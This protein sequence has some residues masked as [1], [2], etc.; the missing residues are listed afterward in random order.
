MPLHGAVMLTVIVW[1]Q[2]R[3]ACA[4]TGATCACTTS[5]RP[6]WQTWRTACAL[7]R[8]TTS[9]AR[10]SRPSPGLCRCGKPS[11]QTLD[12][13]HRT[14][15]SPSRLSPGLCRCGKPTLQ[16]LD[17]PHRTRKEACYHLVLSSH[18]PSPGLRWRALPDPP[19]LGTPHPRPAA[20]SCAGPIGL[21]GHA[22]VRGAD[23][24]APSIARR[25]GAGL[26]VMQSPPCISTPV[27]MHPHQ[28]LP[29]IVL[30]SCMRRRA[31][32][33]RTSARPLQYDGQ[34]RQALLARSVSVGRFA[35]RCGH[36]RRG[37]MHQSHFLSSQAGHLSMLAVLRRL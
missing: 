1:G 22:L 18:G 37:C 26:T 24:W 35:W 8:A 33:S 12:T 16:T 5:A 32:T 29:K 3:A 6:F 30:V 17:T 20:A 9:R 11:L 15:A 14:R 23:L 13:P 21:S 28:P 27:H 2:A 36:V 19:A 4:S 7:R 34:Q 10:P 25:G 31:F